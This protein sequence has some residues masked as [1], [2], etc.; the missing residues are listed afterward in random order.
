MIICVTGTPGTG[1]TKISKC[2]S[3]KLGFYYLD[4]NL[5]IDKYKLKESFDKTRN[6]FVVDVKK[7]EKSVFSEI[8]EILK[9]NR[10]KEKKK[11]LKTKGIE[12]L[13]NNFIIDSHMSHFFSNKKIN[14]CIVCRCNLKVLKNRLIKRKYKNKKIQENLDS[15]IF[16]TCLLEAQEKKHNILEIETDKDIND[17]IATILEKIPENIKN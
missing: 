12:S 9:Q 16:E 13:N 5:I 1:K 10:L 17:V 2:L 4:I 14:L 6:C 3:K 7:L 15:E 11:N 8:N